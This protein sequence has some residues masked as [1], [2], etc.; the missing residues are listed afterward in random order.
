MSTTLDQEVKTDDETLAKI[1][2]VDS[3]MESGR[4]LDSFY[5]ICELWPVNVRPL[6]EHPI[7]ERTL[8][9]IESDLTEK[10]LDPEVKQIFSGVS[11]DRLMNTLLLRKV[12]LYIPRLSCHDHLI[13]EMYPELLSS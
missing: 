2:I 6:P 7:L 5:K 8:R 12:W 13:D 4:S 9:K 10:L 11:N 1:L 3:I